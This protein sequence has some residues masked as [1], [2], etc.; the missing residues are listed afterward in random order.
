MTNETARPFEVA[1]LLYP[2]VSALDAA[3][4]DVKRE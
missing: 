1:I 4:K 2:G 3:A